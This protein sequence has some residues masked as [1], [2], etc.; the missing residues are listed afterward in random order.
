LLE[1]YPGTLGYQIYYS[2]IAACGLCGAYAAYL[3]TKR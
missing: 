1:A 3:L 2:L